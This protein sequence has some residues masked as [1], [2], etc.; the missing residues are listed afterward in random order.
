MLAALGGLPRRRVFGGAALGTSSAGRVAGVTEAVL[1]IEGM[2]DVSKCVAGRTAS[3]MCKA[4]P[5]R[6]ETTCSRFLDTCSNA[7]LACSSKAV[8][9]DLLGRMRLADAQALVR[10]PCKRNIISREL[11]VAKGPCPLLLAPPPDRPARSLFS[12]RAKR[13]SVIAALYN[14]PCYRNQLP[15]IPH[16]VEAR[17]RVCQCTRANVNKRT[18]RMPRTP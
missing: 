5:R 3:S 1:C 13:L 14:E 8:R 18:M 11:H 16:I 10:S 2:R 7:H 17:S 9:L 12:Q 4:L 15:G 6:M